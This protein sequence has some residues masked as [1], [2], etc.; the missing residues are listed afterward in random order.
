MNEDLKIIKHHFGEKM[1]Q[2]CRTLFPA[3]LETEGLL[4]KILINKFDS[5]KYLY[6]DLDIYAKSVEFKN[7]IYSFAE[8]KIERVPVEVD[9]P[10]KLLSDAGYVLYK[11]KTEEDIQAFKKYYERNEELC[12]FN[13]ER[14]NRC[15]V[16]FAVKKNVEEIKREDF[17]NPSRQD[18]YG[19]SVISLQFTKDESCTLSIKNRYNHVVNN[20]DATFSNNLDNIIPGL[21]DSFS[22]HYRMAQKNVN[23]FELPGYVKANDGKY[24]KYN[25]EINNIY[26]CPNN[27]IIDNF[28]AKKLPKEKYI[29]IDYFIFDLQDKKMK[30][31]DETMDDGFIESVSDVSKIQIIKVNG[32][33]EIIISSQQKEGNIKITI[34]KHN[35][36][37]GVFNHNLI[38]AGDDF[39]SHNKILTSLELPNLQGVGDNFLYHNEALTELKLTNLQLT[40]NHFLYY[41]EALAAVELLNLQETG[42]NFLYAN[43]NLT[44]LET[45]NLQEVGDNFLARNQKLTSLKAPKLQITGNDFFLLNQNLTSLET[46]NLQEVGE[47]FLNRNQDLISLELPNLQRAGE[48]FLHYNK[49]LTSLKAPRLQQTGNDFLY[50][51]QEL[52]E[53]ILSNINGRGRWKNEQANNI[54]NK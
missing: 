24:Y 14:L 10:E 1:M 6:E 5:N 28:A 15:H 35:K 29:L 50:N 53:T 49:K 8:E 22:K 44:S 34:D 16:F 52:R 19:T 26:Y 43:Q 4:S 48:C 41:N 9:T 31:Y 3:L 39:L 47:Y 13:G 27:I 42:N 30:Q 11:C 20:P 40:G 37:T 12:T 38:K 46:P 2:L 21:T 25:Y 18:E 17:K 45:P 36:I 23:I 54:R 7:Y 32:G 33:K 51:N